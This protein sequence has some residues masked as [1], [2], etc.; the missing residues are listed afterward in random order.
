MK[1]AL[2]FTLLLLLL[3]SCKRDAPAP[4]RADTRSTIEPSADTAPATESAPNEAAAT[5]TADDVATTTGSGGWPRPAEDPAS[6]SEHWLI[7]LDSEGD[8]EK[9]RA[10]L[11]K[12]VSLDVEMS[13]ATI[14][15]SEFK[16]LMP[17]YDVL[18]AHA[19]K[20]KD[21]ALAYSKALTAKGVG[22][23]PKNA[24]RYVGEQPAV[25]AYCGLGATSSECGDGLYLAVTHDER[26]FIH[27]GLNDDADE[28]AR[29]NG[30]KPTM[31]ERAAWEQPLLAKKRGGL[32]VG[33]DL[34]AVDES[35][36]LMKCKVKGFS[37]LTRG[38]AHFSA[39]DDAPSCGT[40]AV[41]AEL[42]C[43]GAVAAWLP[44][45]PI[46]VAQ[47]VEVRA[48]GPRPSPALLAGA[49]DARL[50]AEAHA[51]EQ[52]RPVIDERTF[53]TWAWKDA[54]WQQGI[55]HLFTGEG[56]D[57]CGGPDFDATLHG[58]E[59]EKGVIRPLEQTWYRETLAVIVEDGEPLEVL[60]ESFG[61]RAI[62]TLRGDERCRLPMAFCDCGC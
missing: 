27:L 2:P 24:G 10:R 4:T 61:D 55:V 21:E 53:E 13:P 45:S 22:N 36:G 52:G 44:S 46:E 5:G 59:D 43:P 60:K 18:I 40:P 54:R 32:T 25:E 26:T 31:I 28:R 8:A 37:A 39:G 58:W 14:K 50:E 3:A 47:R 9:R 19:F 33:D 7:I 20:D 62:S 56:F 12:L 57:E 1:T 35:S 23:Y 15:S 29:Q 41:F 30:R 42:D 48:K 51:K 6:L 11:E 38:E 16:G 49:A 17:C 34:L